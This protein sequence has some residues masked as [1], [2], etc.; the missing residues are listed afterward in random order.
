[1]NNNKII[2][3]F[4]L[5]WVICGIGYAQTDIVGR[6]ISVQGNAYAK[7]QAGEQ[8]VLHRRDG[9]HLRETLTTSTSTKM[10]LMLTDETILTLLPNTEYSVQE[11]KYDRNN[12]KDTKYVGNFVK[13]ALYTISGAGDPNNHE[14][15]TPLTTIGVRGTKYLVYTGEWPL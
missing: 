3:T 9:I 14:L 8:R 1:M 6:V 4:L 5:S 15:K 10:T 12:P 11:L 13:G 2:I 7:S